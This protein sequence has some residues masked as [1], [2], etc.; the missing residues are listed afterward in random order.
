MSNI[1][2]KMRDGTEKKF[3]HEGRAGGS[4]TKEIRY[5]G[6]F[7]IIKDEFYRETVIPMD[8]ILEINIEPNKGWF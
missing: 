7:A 6:N 4:Y 8:L 5:E 2:I 1:I 3:M